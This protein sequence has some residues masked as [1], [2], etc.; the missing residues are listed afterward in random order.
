[1]KTCSKCKIEKEL[2][3]FYK[4]SVSKDGY[5]SECKDCSNKYTQENKES[6]KEYSK[7]RYESVKDTSD[8]KKMRKNWYELNKDSQIEKNKKWRKENKEQIDSY[9]KEYYETNKDEILSKRKE[10]YKR[11][12][13]DSNASEKLKERV[14]RN[15][16]KWRNENKEL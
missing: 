4:K 15:T 12:K 8:F 11:I 9:K 14:R 13:N 5:R 1:M 3:D 7:K 16:K 2:T 10:Y 6:I